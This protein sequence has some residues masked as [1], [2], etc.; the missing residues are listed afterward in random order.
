MKVSFFISVTVT[1]DKLHR[2]LAT[3][4]RSPQIDRESVVV[5]FCLRLDSI[6][7][8]QAGHLIRGESIALPL[9]RHSPVDLEADDKAAPHSFPERSL[10]S[11]P[12]ANASVV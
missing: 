8:A 10:E 9:V 7:R 4:S 1:S 11:L 6:P 12:T 5:L 2:C 3:S